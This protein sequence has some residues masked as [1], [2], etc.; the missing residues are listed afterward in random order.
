MVIESENKNI[1]QS[2]RDLARK[3]LEE[4]QV[5][6]II[7]YSKGTV[8]L[9][10]TP[11]VID[12]VEDVDKLIW[13]NLCYINL[14]KYLVPRIPTLMNEEGKKLKV[15]I[16]S[17]GCVGRAL[18]HL[19]V[20]HQIDLDNIKII[21]IP[22]N[23]IINRKKIEDEIGEREIF[24]ISVSGDN[25]IVKGRDFEQRFPFTEYINELC[26]VCQ[27]KSPPSLADICVG[28]CLENPIIEDDFSDIAD[29]DLK[30]PDEKWEYI[31]NLLETCTR[32]Y[33]C[34]EACPMCYCNLCFVDQNQPVWFGKTTEYSDVFVFH[35]VRAMHMAG[36]CVACGACSSVCPM[37]IDLN[38]IN[39]SLEKIAKERFNFTT[40]IDPK[41]L[42][43]MMAFE[44]E[45]KQEFMVEED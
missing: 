30:T 26:K 4:K 34:R 24:D 2:I 22:C 5:D 15:G 42:P 16:V 23:G 43:P 8:S 35:L 21:G 38:L 9:S 45:D 33:A 1:E 32:C 6:V 17:K 31:K 39:R 36:R 29:F 20:E 28:D 10:S 44:M 37:G 25:I 18:I 12:K 27:V 13:N 40:G 19:S 7:G 41:I 3:L 14:A 11:I